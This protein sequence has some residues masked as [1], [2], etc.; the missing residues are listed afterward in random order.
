MKIFL[1]SHLSQTR[2]GNPWQNSSGWRHRSLRAGGHASRRTRRHG[3]CRGAVL[4]V[5]L[6]ILLAISLLALSFSAAIRTE[7]DASRNVVQQ[8]QSF[9]L[10]RAGIEYAVYRILESQSAFSESQQRQ[11]QRLGQTPE[12]L[13][14]RLRLELYGGGAEV[15]ISDESGKLNLNLTP[16]HLLYN[17]MLAV[18]IEPLEADLITDSIEDWRDADEL[19]RANGAES[20]Y[21]L[22]LDPFYQAKNGPF[23][24]PEELLL[25][26]GVT[27]E[28]FYGRKGLTEAGERVEF[29][30]LQNYLTTFTAANRINLNSAP[31][32]VLAAIPG[33]D[34]DTALQIINLRQQT[35]FREASELL[36]LI[37]GLPTE[38]INYL[39]VLRTNVYSLVSEGR[40]TDSEAISRIRAVIQIDATSRKGY[41]SLYW[42][43]SDIEL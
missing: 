5:V 37:P 43:E 19:Y 30:G 4:I 24:V 22:S 39:A 23:D 28:I 10:A 14:G 16:N 25:V 41:S 13:T 9:Y 42:N 26:R 32:Q 35:P 18:G 6:W 1:F 20:D 8:E 15:Q 11:E 3:P 2:V 38:V 7:V 31:A 21:Y 29:Y 34:F 36:Q 27:L 40:L 17:L 12:V 33:L